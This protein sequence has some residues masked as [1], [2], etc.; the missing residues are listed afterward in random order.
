MG[1][2]GLIT[3][4]NLTASI[5]IQKTGE[6]SAT[7]TYAELAEGIDNIAEALNET[8]QQ[9]FFLSDDGLART[10]VTGMATAFTLTG[11]RVMGDAAQ[12]FIFGTKYSLDTARQSSF[13]LEYTDAEST[14]QTI[15]CDCTICNIQ[16]WSGATTD[17][18]AISFEIRFDGKPTVSPAE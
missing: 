9:Y 3:M 11:K 1:A 18:S 14:K 8:V 13:K 5:G 10:P 16:E 6:P 15:T 2:Y 4:Y 17:D 7:W 12:D